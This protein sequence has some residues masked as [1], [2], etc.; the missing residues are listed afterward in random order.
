MI[1]PPGLDPAAW[2]AELHELSNRLT[3]CCREVDPQSTDHMLA[4]ATD[5]DALV[6]V[7]N[8]PVAEAVTALS[9]TVAAT[10]QPDVPPRVDPLKTWSAPDDFGAGILDAE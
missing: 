6:A 1:T 10:L 8:S 3:A 5:Q 4:H 9:S 2:R 7:E